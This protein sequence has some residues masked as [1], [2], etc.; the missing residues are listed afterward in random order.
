V[1]KS[2]YNGWYFLKIH[3]IKDINTLINFTFDTP[4]PADDDAIVYNGTSGY[5]LYTRSGRTIDFLLQYIY[6]PIQEATLTTTQFK[7]NNTLLNGGQWTLDNPSNLPLELQFSTNISHPLDFHMDAEFCFL[8]HTVVPLVGN[9]IG[10]DRIEFTIER[11]LIEYD[12][13]YSNYLYR[14]YRSN[15]LIEIDS[16][17]LDELSVTF[18]ELE[19]FFECTNLNSGLLL[20]T[21]SSPN[22]ISGARF[23]K[24]SYLI[25]Q[26][27]TRMRTISMNW[28][29]LDVSYINSGFLN[30]TYNSSM[31]SYP[32][33]P[34]ILGYNLD[35][36]QPGWYKV[37]LEYQTLDSTLFSW[38]NDSFFVYR[39]IH[40]T[41]VNATYSLN[42]EPFEIP[43]AIL[44]T[45]TSQ[46]LSQSLF[47][48]R[49]EKISPTGAYLPSIVE[50]KIHIIPSQYS[51]GIYQ[52][53]ITIQAHNF[54]NCTILYRLNFVD[55]LGIYFRLNDAKYYEVILD[56]AS[57]T[58]V[59]DVDNMIFYDSNIAEGQIMHV[60]QASFESLHSF[61]KLVFTTT[62]QSSDDIDPQDLLHL[63]LDADVGNVFNLREYYDGLQMDFY[64]RLQ[65]LVG[66]DNSFTVYIHIT[67]QEVDGALTKL[68]G[69][70][71]TKL[72]MESEF[73][74][75]KFL[76]EKSTI[77]YFQSNEQLVFL[78]LGDTMLLI[79][80]VL[81]C[82]VFL[83]AIIALVRFA[84]KVGMTASL[85]I[86]N[87]VLSHYSQEILQNAQSR[88]RNVEFSRNPVR[89]IS[90]E[91]V[92]SLIQNENL[93]P[94][95]REFILADLQH[96]RDKVGKKIPQKAEVS[97]KV[98]DSKQYDVILPMNILNEKHLQVNMSIPGWIDSKY[99]TAGRRLLMVLIGG[100]SF[101]ISIILNYFTGFP[102]I[103]SL[104]EFVN[105]LLFLALIVGL[106][107][108]IYVPI[109]NYAFTPRLSSRDARRL[110]NDLRN[111]GLLHD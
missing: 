4:D 41:I 28:S 37:S 42:G 67:D 79:I 96:Y 17:Q 48:V 5:V 56:S 75:P 7:I 71:E 84:G 78:Q 103:G 62:A 110:I 72:Y 52:F 11:E 97:S 1:N 98:N 16:A 6:R 64:L 109:V 65:S 49:V 93:P 39:S 89:M 68:T 30:I 51:V 18:T 45:I 44:D 107:V 95:Q 106:M 38:F 87:N 86:V 9:K 54:E 2:T 15:P 46:S 73:H 104:P 34:E 63:E 92:V 23:E 33:T 77:S 69:T 91:A 94:E 108:V 53:N 12:T 58:Q 31:Q 36:S 74:Q 10:N 105:L 29:F 59:R 19:T 14:I 27:F 85:N 13:S 47:S 76:V 101:G 100:L 88:Y 111:E 82:L 60:G 61:I 21:L 90:E 81:A 50:S 83:I 22:L 43:F 35:I 102:F 26:F 40:T 80:I 57:F 20:L 3:E 8:S 70:L 99:G 32:V 24:D 25:T 55:Q 66:T